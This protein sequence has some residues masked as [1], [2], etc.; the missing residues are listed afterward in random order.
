MSLNPTGRLIILLIRPIL[1]Q[2]T[3]KPLTNSA[4]EDRHPTNVVRTN[5]VGDKVRALKQYCRARGLCYR[6][7]EKWSYGHQC[8]STVQ[9][10]AIQELWELLPEDRAA[11]VV[12]EDTFY[13]CFSLKMQWQVLNHPSR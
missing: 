6:C 2:K 7:A 3:V 8:V 5:S 10:H 1:Q 13:V 12:S 9:L 4:A 11:R